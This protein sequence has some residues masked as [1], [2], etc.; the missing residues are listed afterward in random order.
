MNILLSYTYVSCLSFTTNPIILYP[1]SPY[2]SISPLPS[3]ITY[4]YHHAILLPLPPYLYLLLLPYYSLSFNYPIISHPIIYPFGINYSTILS[5]PIASTLALILVYPLY[6]YI[7]ASRLPHPS[8]PIIAACGICGQCTPYIIS[9]I[10][11]VYPRPFYHM[12]AYL[13]YPHP[14]TLISLGRYMRPAHQG[15]VQVKS[16]NTGIITIVNYNTM[17]SKHSRMFTFTHEIG[18]NFGAHVSR[19]TRPI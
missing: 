5:K 3:Y 14:S 18:H 19:R 2:I 4:L 1:I 17:T 6:P 12:L 16:F 8:Y 9:Y 7:I 15:E 10:S 11:L 13:V